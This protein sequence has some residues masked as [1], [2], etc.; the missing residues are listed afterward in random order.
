MASMDDYPEEL[1]PE[2]EAAGAVKTPF[3][4]W[5]L[6]AKEHFTNVPEEVARYWLHEHW[7]H[8]PYSYLASSQYQF[9]LQEWPAERLLEVRSTWC[10]FSP[11]NG[12]CLE[13]GWQLVERPM[14]NQQL[15]PTAAYMLAH[16]NFP[17][18]IIV[19]DN[20]DG[21]LAADKATAWDRLPNTLVLIEGHRRFNI[22]LYLHKTGRLNASVH[23]WAM[24]HIVAP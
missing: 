17:T 11:D 4:E 20:R 13:K 5:W 14:L 6:R 21:H 19:L 8:S 10:R 3:E 1:A 18:P 9:E 16:K 23:V 2:F 24:T 12:E 15:Y 7:G 22:G